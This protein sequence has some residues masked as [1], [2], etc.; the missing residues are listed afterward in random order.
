MNPPFHVLEWCGNDC[1]TDSEY[2][3]FMVT[4]F[5]RDL[6]GSTTSVRFS[7][8]PSFLI[9][10]KTE[11]EC[12]KQRLQKVLDVACDV[13]G[14]CLHC[15]SGFVLG[16]P[17]TGWQLDEEDFLRL[18]F[19]TRRSMKKFGSV[20]RT[21]RLDPDY[22]DEVPDWFHRGRFGFETYELD[23]DLVLQALT[24]HGIPPTGWLRADNVTGCSPSRLT[25]CKVHYE[26][27]PVVLD[28]A[29]V[30]QG[31]APHVV[32]TFDIETLSS[33]S[34]W[35]EQIFPDATFPDD[36]V[37]QV[38]T[39]FSRFGD[40]DPYDAESLVLLPPGAETPTTTVVESII[41]VRVRYFRHE[42]QL[43]NAWVKSYADRGVSVW[44]HFNGLGFDEA[45]MHVRC[46]MHRV[47]MSVMSLARERYPTRLAES[48]L[49]T[50]AYGCN[51]FKTMQLSGV[52]HLDVMQDIKK[53]HNLGFWAQG[54]ESEVQGLEIRT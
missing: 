18:V 26:T 48:R 36:A 11:E 52:F 20:F 29:D 47:D 4:G 6:S 28:D 17:F 19:V 50:S 45:Y 49:E 21:D 12:V 27:I 7:H 30:P 8:L 23:A 44:C 39:F 40:S 37:T 2:G 14:D 33:R 38:C 34:T 1:Y 13:L 15:S 3:S 53:S 42:A 25:K 46:S 32:A 31:C 10:C 54:L 43:L 9:R 16:K 41:P 51:V 35:E 5:G 24:S 22:V